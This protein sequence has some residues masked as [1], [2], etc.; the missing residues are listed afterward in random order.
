VTELGRINYSPT[1]KRVEEGRALGASFLP[2]EWYR[3]GTVLTH[4]G[5]EWAQ[6]SHPGIARAEVYHPGIARAEV[7]HPVYMQGAHIP[8]GVHAGCTYTT[9]VPERHEGYTPGYLRDMR[10]THPCST[11]G[12]VYHPCSTAGEVYTPCSM[13][14]IHPV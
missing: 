1:V 11:A 5:I 2:K 10:D 12:E 3:M 8:P 14:A 9:R 7:Y 13:V 6:F 4:P